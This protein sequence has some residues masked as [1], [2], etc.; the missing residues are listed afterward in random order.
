MTIMQAT[1]KAM[2]ETGRDI[3]IIA[4]TVQNQT[5]MITKK[6]G[7]VPAAE[8]IELIRQY[9]HE[10][11]MTKEAFHGILSIKRPYRWIYSLMQRLKNYIICT[12]KFGM[13]ILLLP[14]VKTTMAQLTMTF[15]PNSSKAKKLS[16]F[17]QLYK[18]RSINSPTTRL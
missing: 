5:P 11:I 4:L 9:I 10:G 12:P 18:Y 3:H 1:I 8:E 15:R 6:N 17:I 2:F 7:C 16:F 13:E 14:R